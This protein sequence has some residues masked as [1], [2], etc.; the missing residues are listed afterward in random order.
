MKSVDFAQDQN[1]NDTITHING[2]V[3]SSASISDFTSTDTRF[4]WTQWGCCDA[5]PTIDSSITSLT[6]TGVG[7]TYSPT[8]TA[9]VGGRPS[10]PIAK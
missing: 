5:I 9:L 3:V 8:L 6:C 7:G 10:R 2:S 1:I 4:C